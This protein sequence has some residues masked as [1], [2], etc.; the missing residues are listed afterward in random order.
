MWKAGKRHG[1]GTLWYDDGSYFDGYWNTNARIEGTM[2]M[3]NGTV[4]I[5][6]KY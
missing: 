2:K 3:S 5:I 1:Q 6:H 4:S